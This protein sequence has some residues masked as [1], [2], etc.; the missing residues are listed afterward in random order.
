MWNKELY[1]NAFRSA[2]F[3]IYGILLLNGIFIQWFAPFHY[4]CDFSEKKCFACG[5]RTAV[6]LS[7]QGRFAEAYASNHLILVIALLL[8][9][10]AADVSLCLYKEYR[11]KQ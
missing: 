10:M 11:T 1:R 5:M 9:F 2:R 7:L 6:D 4:L 3:C 8:L